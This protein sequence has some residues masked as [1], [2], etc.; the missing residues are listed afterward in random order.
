LSFVQYWPVFCLFAVNNLSLDE[1]S[2]VGATDAWFSFLLPLQ[3]SLSASIPL[4]ASSTPAL[5]TSQHVE[6]AML[7]TH[8]LDVLPTVLA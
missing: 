6:V 1:P 7:F 5:P 3:Y 8:V 4:T 2:S